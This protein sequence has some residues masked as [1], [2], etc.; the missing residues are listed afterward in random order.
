M[1]KQ[2]LLGLKKDLGMYHGEARLGEKPIVYWPLEI[3]K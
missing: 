1:V 3:K 2:A